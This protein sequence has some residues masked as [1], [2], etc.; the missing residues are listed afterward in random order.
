MEDLSC[1]LRVES[2]TERLE[3]MVLCSHGG[4]E[5]QVR[6]GEIVLASLSSKETHTWLP[7]SK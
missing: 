7:E 6:R 1:S 2:K 4:R 5:A 3:F